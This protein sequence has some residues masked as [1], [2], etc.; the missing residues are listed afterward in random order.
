MSDKKLVLVVGATGGQGGSVARHL[1]A[2]GRFAVRALTRNP[3]SETA[4]ALADAGAEVVRGDLDD[5]QSIRHALRG[6]WGAFGVTNFWEHFGREYEHGRNLIDAVAES[7]VEHFVFSA[8]P[9]PHRISGGELPV[10]HFDIKAQLEDHVRERGIPA[11]IIHVASYYENF[12]SH[13]LPRRQEDGSFVF[14]FPQGDAPLAQVSVEDVGGVVAAI[15]ARPEEFRGRTVT[16]VAEDRPAAE[17]A[18]VFTR[19]LGVPVSYRHVPRE[20]YASLGFPGAGDLANMFDYNRRFV[21]SRA[22]EIE[23]TRRL[24]P[25]AR[26]FEPWVAANRERLLAAMTS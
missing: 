14:G 5:A 4:R 9:S 23:E 24:Y 21:P 26:A 11:T 10:P 25:E 12:L 18:A 1:L 19:V 15:F 7:G 8:L 3:E 22:A 17:Y 16:I 13:F 20:V 6:C 2:D